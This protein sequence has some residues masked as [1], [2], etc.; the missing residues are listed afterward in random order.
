MKTHKPLTSTFLTPIRR[1]L[2]LDRLFFRF[3][4]L[5]S[6]LLAASFGLLGPFFQKVFIDYLQSPNQAITFLQ[7]FG[8][9]LPQ[10]LNSGSDWG[11]LVPLLLAFLCL[12][13]Q[14]F[15]ALFTNF[16]GIKEGLVAQR[17]I[18]GLLYEKVLSLKPDTQ[19]KKTTGEIVAFYTTDV[20]GA[21]FFL[22]QTL[23][24]GAATLF[25]II[26]APIALSM[27]FEIPQWMTFSLIIFI[28]LIFMILALRQ[29]RFFFN[30]KQLA[31]ERIA[32]VNE[33]V[34]YLKTLRI[35]GWIEAFEQRI[36]AKRQVETKNRILMVTNGQF[37]NAI[38]THIT[39]ILN[40]LALFL[41]IIV[42]KRSPTPGDLFA[43][44]WILGVFLLRPFR[45][46]PWFFT[47]GFDA[48]TSIKRLENYFRVEN[49]PSSFDFIDKKS[50]EI[51][52]TVPSSAVASEYSLNIEN[53]SLKIGD[54]TILSNIS[55]QTR[56]GEMIALIGEVGSGK[57]LLLLSLLGETQAH[58]DK[59]EIF[60]RPISSFREDE[61]RKS[62]SYV[63]QET[64]L[65]STSLRN[66][67]LL[68]YQNDFAD[69]E[70]TKTSLG[71]AEF[72]LD[73]E[74]LPSGLETEIGERG[75]NLSGGQKQRVN[76]ARANS[77]DC[78][79]LL[80]DDT[81]SALD[82]N[83][84]NNVISN[85]IAQKITQ[86]TIFISTHRLSVLPKCDR[87]LFLQNGKIKAFDTYTNLI[88][89]NSDFRNFLS[90]KKHDEAKH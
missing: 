72:H 55:I 51:E 71:Q 53:L 29:S 3:L 43:L 50:P 36:F 87:I 85:L 64:Y 56:P 90:E 14:Q 63:P 59:Y 48:W 42:M 84:E 20:P 27:M 35:L 26:L 52:T 39:F 24:M 15:F 18:A 37:M 44:L 32:F 65:I 34:V 88:N 17:K 22:E 54:E 79:F 31:A 73:T 68:D 61:F 66:N 19:S 13:L 1:V 25:P 67:V 11:G 86:K 78:Y 70:Q 23:P 57:S 82:S 6:S 40:S 33:W 62:F 60:G 83:T 47:F 30:F 12:A 81:L 21:T 76:L 28:T 77:K 2:F 7:R 41:L 80:L 58:F 46:M 45:Q 74:T 10:V 5:A 49:P 4:I 75:V 69:D 8:D 9:K 89:N 16:L 38:S